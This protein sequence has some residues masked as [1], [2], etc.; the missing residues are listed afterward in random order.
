MEAVQDGEG[1]AGWGVRRGA[2]RGLGDEGEEA[3]MGMRNMHCRMQGRRQAKDE[4]ELWD[5]VKA[6]LIDPVCG[7][8]R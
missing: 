4:D 3:S 7:L 1:G 5:C 2:A 6:Y 8:L